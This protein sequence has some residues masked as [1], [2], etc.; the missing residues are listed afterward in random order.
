VIDRD[1]V[2]S[3]LFNVLSGY[4][5]TGLFVLNGLFA[6]W[7]SPRVLRAL[8][9]LRSR[10]VTG[11]LTLSGASASAGVVSL[12]ASP[13]EPLP[14]GTASAIATAMQLPV[15]RPAWVQVPQ[16][17]NN[18]LWMRQQQEEQANAEARF[19]MASTMKGFNAA[20]L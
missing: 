7:L 3:F 1:D 10:D 6:A 20:T 13:P 15:G 2:G 14:P 12:S 8:R 19:A 16:Y 18:T 11:N 17:V 5:G 4:V 9:W